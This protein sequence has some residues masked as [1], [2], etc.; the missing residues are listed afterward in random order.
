MRCKQCKDKFCPKFFN[1]KFCLEKDE[2][3]K[4]HSEKAKADKWKFEK[5]ELTEKLMTHSDYCNLLQPIIN[6]IAR[7][8][9][10][11]VPCISSL[12]SEGKMAGG[13]RW[14]VGSNANLRFNLLNIHQQCFAEN[15]YKSG[16]P[17]GYDHGLSTL[18]GDVYVDEVHSLK[19][20]Y[21]L[22]KWSIPELIHAKARASK[23]NKELKSL[24]MTYSH[25][26]RIELRKKFNNI[27]GLYI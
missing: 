9:D 18:Y 16:N 26:V 6:E 24:D 22:M 14:S 11:D 12:R 3:I 7:L 10:K 1:Q 2:C 27:I 15:S 5:K 25:G 13:H 17:D 20:K 4:A 8:I 23:I 21:P 19:L